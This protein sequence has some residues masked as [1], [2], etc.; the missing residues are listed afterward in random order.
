MEQRIVAL[1]CVGFPCRARR[2]STLR[3]KLSGGPGAA[4]HDRALRVAQNERPQASRHLAQA[5]QKNNPLAASAM[6]MAALQIN[7][8]DDAVTVGWLRK[9]LRELS[10]AERS[11]WLTRAPF[12][13]LWQK[14]SPAWV[15]LLDEFSVPANRAE[16]QALAESPQQEEVRP[17]EPEK[18]ASPLRL[19]PF[20]PDLSLDQ[21]TMQIEQQIDQRLISRIR[22]TG[23][24]ALPLDLPTD[25][26]KELQEP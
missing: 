9:G 16:A 23:D 13:A 11:Y 6:A 5:L 15:E 10:A 7:P 20:N 12:D 18:D 19:S 4:P 14:A 2:I 26:E 21:Q 24:D 25:P 8:G 17:P 22:P 3:K 1:S